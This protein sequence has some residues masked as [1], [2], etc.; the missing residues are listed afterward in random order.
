MNNIYVLNK[1]YKKIGTLSNEGA[2]P[3]AP[4]YED[5]YVQELETGADTYQFSTTSSKY[6]QDILEVGNHIMFAYKNRNELFTITSLEYSHYEGYKTIG[7]YAEGIGFDLL[8]IYM[9]KP[10][11]NSSDSGGGRDEDN[12]GDDNTDDEYADVDDVYLDE[13]GIIIYDEYGGTEPSEEDVYVDENGIIIYRRSKN[14]RKNDSLEFKNISYPTFLNILLKGTGWSYVCQPGLESIKHDITVRYD[15]N[16]YAILQDS[17][18]DYKGVELEFVHEYNNG[19]VQKLIKAYKDG[20]R[21]SFVGKRFEY[22]VNVRGITKTQEVANSEDDTVLRIDNVGIDITYDVDFALKSIEVPEIEIGDTHYVID[23]DFYPPM[24]IKARIGKIEISFSD[25][26]RN[27]IYLANNKRIS[28]SAIEDELD[29]DT[30]KDL[31]DDNTPEIEEE[32]PEDPTTPLIPVAGSNDMIKAPRMHSYEFLLYTNVDDVPNSSGAFRVNDAACVDLAPEAFD[33]F[34]NKEI[35]DYLMYGIDVWDVS[36]KALDTL[37]YNKTGTPVPS[38]KCFRLIPNDGSKVNFSPICMNE[39]GLGSSGGYGDTDYMR[40]CEHYNEVSTRIFSDIMGAEDRPDFDIANLNPISSNHFDK[41]MLDVGS[42][43]C[44]LVS[45]LQYHVKKVHGSSSGDDSSDGSSGGDYGEDIDC[46]TLCANNITVYEQFDTEKLVATTSALV[47]DLTAGG[48]T[49]LRDKVT[50]PDG[51]ICTSNGWTW[52]SGSSGNT[53]GDSGDT[54]SGDNT[55]Y[56]DDITCNSLTANSLVNTPTLQTS[57]VDGYQADL[58]ILTVGEYIELPDGTKI[59]GK[60]DLGGS[61][62]N[63]SSGTGDSEGDSSGSSGSTASGI[64][65]GV[66]EYCEEETSAQWLGTSWVQVNNDLKVNGHLLVSGGNLVGVDI[67]ENISSIIFADGTELT[68]ASGVSAVSTVSELSEYATVEVLQ[69]ELRIRDE[70]IANLES[71]LAA[72]EALL[73]NNDN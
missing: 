11:D 39:S 60:E 13:N 53:S 15:R 58:A 9:K 47:G 31:I 19:S 36:Y 70:Q 65:D 73:N 29:E 68:S 5:L 71:R 61:S 12:D 38:N 8:E 7:V 2:N 45:A 54:G 34:S 33:T 17:M 37:R 49:R 41:H 51:T 56:G 28:G 44:G 30:I 10:D 18:Q 46:N 42:L 64:P 52:A 67:L 27:K 4:Y 43:A 1:N 59:Y 32:D 16:I 3:Q 55:S 69:E 6:T 23:K 26:T 14:N 21:G 63:D 20:G 25:P 35:H 48:V 66:I 72:I 22:G 57:L 62:S 50:F 40:E 24:T